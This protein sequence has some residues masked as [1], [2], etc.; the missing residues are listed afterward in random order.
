MN[1][2]VTP[3]V[4]DRSTS[5]SRPNDSRERRHRL[6]TEHPVLQID[7]ANSSFSQ[8]PED[9]GQK[10]AAEHGIG[11]LRK[12]IG[13]C[14]DH[15]ARKRN[16]PLFARRKQGGPVLLAV[17]IGAEFPGRNRRAGSESE[18]VVAGE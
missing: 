6:H 7:A 16:E 2:I 17:Q 1:A 9:V 10:F 18:H 4:F 13:R 5:R 12:D 3:S 11:F 15:R 8:E 14:R